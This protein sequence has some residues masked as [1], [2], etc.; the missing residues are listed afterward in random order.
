LDARQPRHCF[1]AEG[2]DRKALA[3]E[4][5]VQ[6]DPSWSPD[7]QFLVVAARDGSGDKLFKIRAGD[8]TSTVLLNAA[9]HYPVWSPDGSFI[10]YR[11]TDKAQL[12]A[13]TPEGSSYPITLPP[14]QFRNAVNNPYRFLPDGKQIVALRGTYR[15]DNFWLVDLR[16]GQMRQITDL[17]PGFSITSFDVSQD[18]KNILF[19]RA[20]QNADVVMI[21]PNQ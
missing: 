21:E 14:L 15:Q 8:G 19:D 18:G 6:D 20:R 4:L 17:R 16:S 9:A 12:Q 1:S 5:D 7:G 3:E 2:T 11:Q 13:V 10:L